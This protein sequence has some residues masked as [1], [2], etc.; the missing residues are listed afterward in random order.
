MKLYTTIS[1]E[2]Y[3]QENNGYVSESGYR[4]RDKFHNSGRR[5]CHTEVTQCLS[6]YV[7]L[8]HEASKGDRNYCLGQSGDCGYA[9]GGVFTG[10]QVRVPG[11]SGARLWAISVVDFY[12]TQWRQF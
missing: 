3:S 9:C 10:G 4:Y 11:A 8:S 5:F 12:W 6:D 1:L 7:G 2:G